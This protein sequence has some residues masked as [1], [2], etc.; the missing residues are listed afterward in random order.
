MGS[1]MGE[2]SNILIFLGLLGAIVVIVSM[3]GGSG[4]YGRWA[5]SK[6]RTRQGASL[7]TAGLGCLIFIDDYFNCLTVGTV[8]RPVTDLS[9]IHISTSGNIQPVFLC[10]GKKRCIHSRT[11]QIVAVRKGNILS[12]GR[13]YPVIT[14]MG[15]AF[16][17]CR[18]Y[19]DP[20]LLLGVFS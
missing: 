4:A 16:V 13:G 3:A 19:P 12:L 1:K 15:R 6:I 7:A 2:N 11:E 10:Q 18:E 20:F 8:M 9:L 14:G 17:L 5:A